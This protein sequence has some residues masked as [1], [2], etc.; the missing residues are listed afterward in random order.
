[1]GLCK[2]EDLLDL[3][4]AWGSC[5]LECEDPLLPDDRGGLDDCLRQVA[6]GEERFKISKVGKQVQN[7]ASS[8]LAISTIVHGDSFNLT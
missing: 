1:M 4:F 2:F 8:N 3:L 5:W 6:Q 7:S